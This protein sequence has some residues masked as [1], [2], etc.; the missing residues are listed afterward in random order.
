MR[1]LASESQRIELQA[2]QIAI[3]DEGL[4]GLAFFREVLM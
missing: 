2:S 1:L 3:R 4:S